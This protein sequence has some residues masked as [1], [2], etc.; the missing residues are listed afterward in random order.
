MLYPLMKRSVLEAARVEFGM[1]PDKTFEIQEPA[2]ITEDWI[3][4][5]L[6]TSG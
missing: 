1:T 5:E 6:D 3:L 4:G 2:D